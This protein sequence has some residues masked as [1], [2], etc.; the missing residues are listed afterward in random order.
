MEETQADPWIGKI[1]GGEHS[2]Q[3]Q[4]SCLENPM[5]RGA[6]Q[7][8]VH[9]VVKSWT[10]LKPLSTHTHTHTHTQGTKRPYAMQG[11]QEIKFKK[12]NLWET[13]LESMMHKSI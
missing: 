1:P 4:Y 9:R 6:E 13:L 7:A 11:G 12:K 5:D 3:L 10:R 2:T 8:M